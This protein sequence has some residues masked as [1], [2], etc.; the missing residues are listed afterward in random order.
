MNKPTESELQLQI[1]NRLVEELSQRQREFQTL[2]DLLEE[3][4]LRL[5]PDGTIRLLNPS[6]VNKLGYP[7]QT[8]LGSDLTSFVSSAP[9][10]AALR[11]ALRSDL[12][13]MQ[14]LKLATGF[15]E[16]RDFVLRASREGDAWYGSLFDVTDQQ[17]TLQAL[18]ES[19]NRARK[20]SLVAQRTDNLV[21]ITDRHGRVDWVNAGFEKA[22]GYVL[23]EVKGYRPGAILQG[24]LTD[25]ATVRHMSEAL[26]QGQGFSVEVVN[27]NKQGTPYWVSIDCDP[28]HDVDGQLQ[29]FI[30][31][32]RDITRAKQA[33][34]DM[35]T[36]RDEAQQLSR[37]R[38]RFVANMSHE[39]RT[40][41]NAMLGMSSLLADTPLSAEQKSY[42]DT[43]QNSG[44]ALL[45]L[46][47]DVLDFAKL[48]SGQ[49]PFESMPFM[50]AEPFEEAVDIVAP[51]LREKRVGLGLSFA[52]EVPAS[53]VGDH[54]RL[55][56]VVLNLLSNAAKFTAQGHIHVHV[57]WAQRGADPGCLRVTVA[58]TGIGIEP[59]RVDALFNE[60]TQADP[61]ITRKFGGTGLGL[62]ICR[63]ICEQSGG[64]IWAESRLGAGSCFKFEMQLPAGQLAAESPVNW[65][66]QHAEVAPYRQ[67]VIATLAQVG[68]TIRGPN[69]P[70]GP[71]RLSV[72]QADGRET[73]VELSPL[74]DIL[75]PRRLRQQ[76]ALAVDGEPARPSRPTRL[77]ETG[78]GLRVLIAEDV[79]PNQLVLRLMLERLGCQDIVV[80]DDGQ[81]A[82]HAIEREPFDLVLTDMHMPVL[83]GLDAATAI[84]GLDLA[85]QP[86]IAIVS[87]DATTD[88]RDA[89]RRSGIDRWVSKPVNRSELADLLAQVQAR[90]AAAA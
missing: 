84:R 11:E 76:I 22:T 45:A 69:A 43:V 18:R 7:V 26:S 78:A 37:E 34:A 51:S 4:V 54:N 79:A 46:V 25:A 12:S 82:I 44:K 38:T 1:N 31:I 36:A 10:R 16:V 77:P 73:A 24:P 67:Q 47:N 85:H 61:S 21:V 15:G 75:T 60:F 59:E 81:Q 58:D 56:Q 2:I 9:A 48:E 88:A 32:E 30:A 70:C 62:A 27:Y 6:W 52:P 40:P 65:V 87:A 66:L 63:Q 83:D 53:L 90:S 89:A 29:S 72:I 74:Y 14:E 68:A 28:V 33:E 8:C 64:R 41:L 80:V 71:E 42:L 55:R 57:G 5:D 35:R 19:E 13:I 17:R 86:L 3:I 50:T 23:A 49:L 39:I 20:L